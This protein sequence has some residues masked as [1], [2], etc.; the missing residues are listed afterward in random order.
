MYLFTDISF[1]VIMYFLL[2]TESMSA[3]NK[4][5]PEWFSWH[6]FRD[7]ILLSISTGTLEECLSLFEDWIFLFTVY[8]P[9]DWNRICFCRMFTVIQQIIYSL[10]KPT[11]LIYINLCR[12]DLQIWFREKSL[13]RILLFSFFAL[14]SVFGKQFYN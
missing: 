10:N 12:D 4:I 14:C 6:C 5:T 2:I 8:Q 11:D 3:E 13:N 7:A 1:N 9:S